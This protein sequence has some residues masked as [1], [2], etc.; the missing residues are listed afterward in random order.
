MDAALDTGPQSPPRITLT[1]DFGAR[2][3]YVA[4]M[5]GVILSIC[6]EARIEDLSHDIA[7]QGIMEGALFL[8]AAAPYWPLG[9]CHVAV[10]DPGVGT[11]RRPVAVAAGGQVFV[12]PDN[13][14][15]TLF[16]RAYPVQ[17]AREIANPAFLRPKIS[18]TFH[19]RDIFAPA[20][21]HLAMG[22]P[23]DAIGP[24]VDDLQSLTIPE[25][26]VDAGLVHGL[27][28]HV[29]RFGNAITNIPRAML[30]PGALYRL[31]AAALSISEISHTYASVRPGDSVALFGSSGHVEIAVRNG[32][33]QKD[34]H[35][36]AG[37]P[38]TLYRP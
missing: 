5:K 26:T 1:T 7:P 18:P 29:D 11:E 32:S 28:V 16:L 37:D 2:D 33:A 4:A 21:A 22:M 6:P 8:A 30:E 23:F 36:K 25:P 31:H 34:F 10:V 9:T 3:P 17:A 38:V 13:G 20:A 19:G 14:L 35:L 15:L 27:I 24:A 12:C